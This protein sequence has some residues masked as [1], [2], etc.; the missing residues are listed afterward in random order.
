MNSHPTAI[1]SQKAEIDTTVRIGPFAIIEDDVKLARNVRVHAHAYIANGARIGEGTEVH[2]GAV[3]G[4]VPQDVAFK[5]KRSFLKIG[6]NNVIREY[7][8]IHRG[9][10]ESTATEIGDGN[11][12]MTHSHVG[13]NCRVGNKAILANGALIAGYVEVDDGAFISGNV[14][15]HQFCRVGKL[16]LIGGFSGVNKDVPPYMIVRGPS[17]VRAVNVIGLSRAGFEKG[18]IKEI[19]EAYRLIYKSGLNTSQATAKI[20]RDS[21]GREVAHLVD[22]IGKSKR[23]ICRHRFSAEGEGVKRPGEIETKEEEYGEV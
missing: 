14:V 20:L 21:P 5:G 4:H 2:M 11:F 19:K 8:T 10:K 12:F 9:T 3:L 13:H 6:K 18:A 22:F 15:V 16:A 23:G 1:V 17:E 7:V